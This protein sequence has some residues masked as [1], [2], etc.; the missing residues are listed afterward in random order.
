MGAICGELG[1]KRGLY[2]GETDEGDRAAATVAAE[3]A[4]AWM[5]AAGACRP[6]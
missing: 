3:A 4:A 5:G 2:M 1:E 6:G